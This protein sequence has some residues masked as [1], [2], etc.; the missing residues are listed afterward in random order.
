MLN[1]FATILENFSN[2]TP[3]F[4]VLVFLF[5]VIFI[6][7]INAGKGR[8]ILILLSL[9]IAV[10]LTSLFPYQQYLIENIKAGEPYF[11]ELGLFIV[12]FF[13]VLILFLNSPLRSIAVKSRG[14]I[15]QVLVLSILILGVFV[16]YITVLLPAEI[17]AKLDHKIFTY[18]KTET[19]Q[20]WWAL[21][22]VVGLAALRR[23]GE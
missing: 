2:P 12:S 22:G 21:A 4:L 5:L 19:T 8:M 15:F 16:S 17:L 7:G 10:I 23:R 1:N 20:F 9:Y 11:V 13:I 18:F 14:H 3:Y 6:Y